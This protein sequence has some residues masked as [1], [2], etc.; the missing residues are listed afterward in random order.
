MPPVNTTCPAD[1]M[2]FGPGAEEAGVVGAEMMEAR[3]RHASIAA[4]LYGAGGGL[5]GSAMASG[6]A[7][8]G[9]F[10]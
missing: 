8:A 4:A 6:R 9:W 3:E 5:L 10:E 1:E 7:A 2:P